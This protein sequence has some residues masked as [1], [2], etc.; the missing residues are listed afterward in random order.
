MTSLINNLIP[1]RPDV[2]VSDCPPLLSL[3]H[4]NSRRRR[5]AFRHARNPRRADV[6][7]SAAERG[8]VDDRV[9]GLDGHG[10]AA[11]FVADRVDEFSAERLIVAAEGHRPADQENLG[12]DGVQDIRHPDAQVARRFHDD[13]VRERIARRGGRGHIERCQFVAVSLQLAERTFAAGFECFMEA[14][15][16]GRRAAVRFEMPALS[17]AAPTRVVAGIDDQVPDLAAE[18]VRAADQVIVDDDPAADTRAERHQ[19][20]AVMIAAAA[21]PKLAVCRG[22]GVIDQRDRDADVIFEQC[23]DRRIV[24]SR[25]IVRA[26]QLARLGIDHPRNAHADSCDVMQRQPQRIDD[27]ADGRVQA[28]KRRGVTTARFRRDGAIGERAPGRINQADLD[29]GAADIIAHK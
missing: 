25:Q 13:L 9:L 6:T 15:L 16:H 29:R 2:C 27:A 22:V 12:V 3:P 20:E 26:D 5:F 19:H 8:E 7:R 1:H 28:L 4:R 14:V 18:I 23:R 11:D 10:T 24:P 17:A 21:D